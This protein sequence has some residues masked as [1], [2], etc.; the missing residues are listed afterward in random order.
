MGNIKIPSQEQTV[1]KHLKKYG[2]ITAREAS[3]KYDIDRLSGR[4]FNLRKDHDII[5]VTESNK[6]R[7]GTHARYVYKGEKDVQV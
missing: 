4:I 5:T 1:L 7:R 2:S 6:R 3:R